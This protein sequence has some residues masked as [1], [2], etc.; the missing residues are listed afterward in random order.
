MKFPAKIMLCRNSM[1][2][3]VGSRIRMRNLQ[4]CF[5]H[6]I[7]KCGMDDKKCT[8]TIYEKLKKE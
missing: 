8:A 6:N 3:N 1:Q 5:W 2:V 4:E 7:G